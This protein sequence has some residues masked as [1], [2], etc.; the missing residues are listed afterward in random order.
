MTAH[1]LADIARVVETLIASRLEDGIDTRQSVV[2]SPADNMHNGMSIIEDYRSE[3]QRDGGSGT[4]P[5]YLY[6]ADDG[7]PL[8]PVLFQLDGNGNPVKQMVDDDGL[9][10]YPPIIG[11]A[12]AEDESLVFGDYLVE[13]AT[14]EG[15]RLVPLNMG[16]RKP[17]HTCGSPLQGIKVYV[18]N[19]VVQWEGHTVEPVTGITSSPFYDVPQTTGES[20]DV[21]LHIR[22]HST[23]DPKFSPA[24]MRWTLTS[25]S[26]LE[27]SI[28]HEK[29]A[30]WV[31]VTDFSSDMVYYT[32][33]N[34]R[35]TGTARIGRTGTDTEETGLSTE[36][37]SIQRRDGDKQAVELYRWRDPQGVGQLSEGESFKLLVRFTDTSGNVYLRYIDGEAPSDHTGLT[38]LVWNLSDHVASSGNGGKLAGF[39]SGLAAVYYSFD[40]IADYVWSQQSIYI[41]TLHHSAL[42]KLRWP[43][44]GHTSGDSEAGIAGFD[45]EG[46]AVKL[47]F[48]TLA[49]G[50]NHN[51]HA[52]MQGGSATER[53]HLTASEHTRLVDISEGAKAANV[54]DATD[55]D[56][57]ITL[58]NAI[59]AV[60]VNHN[61]MEPDA[62]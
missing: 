51:D 54:A 21:Y 52:G 26:E 48:G 47:T 7:D 18:A 30:S 39:N 49:A 10:A 20:G 14:E 59:K 33:I 19:A 56:S 22:R 38:N 53:Y 46:K 50:H 40:D 15:V 1:D 25:S 37:F 34:Q 43:E 55:L 12:A 3:P 28:Y 29:I 42:D 24:N 60:L 61:M 32:K 27:N 6:G 41:G 44:S 5:I 57:A 31:H 13:V 2:F 62:P 35:H 23:S 58:L 11:R 45:N 16:P 9:P 17:F 4:T 36:S 8:V